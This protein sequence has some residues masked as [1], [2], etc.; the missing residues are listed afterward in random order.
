[1]RSVLPPLLLL[2]LL[3]CGEDDA[4]PA[5][6]SK[7]KVKAAAPAPLAP[8]TKAEQEA[9]QAGEDAA[10]VLRRYYDHIEAGRYGAAWAMRGGKADGAAAF[11]AN[12][13]EYERYRVTVG[14]AT[15]PVSGGGWT[16]VEVPIQIYGRMTGG[17]PFGSAG[18]VSLRRA[19][20]AR[21]ATA[22]QKEWHI[23]TGE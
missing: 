23:Y 11:A 19:A 14:R 21:D 2:A 5:P 12:F 7:A 10:A 13:A 16:Y 6:P 3:G 22:A 1:M 4:P 8:P 20:G 17:E 15:V 18:S 9:E